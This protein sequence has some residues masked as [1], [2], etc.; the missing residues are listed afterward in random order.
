MHP[1][2]LASIAPLAIAAGAGIAGLAL[3]ALIIR[4][5]RPQTLALG[6]ATTTA[7]WGLAAIQC[8]ALV[9]DAQPAS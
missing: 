3:F 2:L 6:F 9:P 4:S 8:L 1:I 7:Q 5:V